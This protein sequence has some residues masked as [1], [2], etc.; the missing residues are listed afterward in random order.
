MLPTKT[1]EILVKIH[2]T[3]K[4]PGV[5]KIISGRTYR[6]RSLIY[7]RNIYLDSTSKELIRKCATNTKIHDVQNVTI[8]NEWTKMFIVMLLKSKRLKMTQ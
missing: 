1:H 3:G 4:N 7:T 6:R 8:L 2:L 5:K